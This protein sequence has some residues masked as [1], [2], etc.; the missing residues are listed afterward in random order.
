MLKSN[1]DIRV[2]DVRFCALGPEGITILCEALKANT[3]VERVLALANNLGGDG[4]AAIEKLLEKKTDKDQI[5]YLD[6]Q[7]N[8][9]PSVQKT[10]LRA[11]AAKVS[12][13]M[14]LVIDAVD[15]V[16]GV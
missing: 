16:A 5:K 9:F 2:L 14:V 1:D 6:L 11:T 3:S 7:D 4:C 12:P 15:S 10:S 8:L 13:G